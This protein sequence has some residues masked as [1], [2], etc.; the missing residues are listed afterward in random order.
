MAT[1]SST[2]QQSAFAYP[3]E[4]ASLILAAIKITIIIINNAWKG[5][6]DAFGC[7]S[8][9]IIRKLTHYLRLFG[10]NGKRR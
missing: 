9:R 4:S 6:A 2:P 7:D 5:F 10:G 3:L 8:I 1:L